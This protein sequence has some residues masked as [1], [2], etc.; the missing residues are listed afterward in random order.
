MQLAEIEMQIC[1]P[2]NCMGT[3][4]KQHVLYDVG[5]ARQSRDARQPRTVEF[6]SRLSAVV[7][8]WLPHSR[9]KGT[10]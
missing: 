10:T 6:S 7:H 2:C 4:L 5:T 3:P 8:T 1:W 9:P